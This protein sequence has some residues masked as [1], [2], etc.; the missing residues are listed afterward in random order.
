M[1]SSRP[2]ARSTSL[3]DSDA[4]M[5]GASGWDAIEWTK[6]EPFSR[7]V[8]LGNLECLLEAEQIVA[9][10]VCGKRVFLSSW[11]DWVAKNVI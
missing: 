8:S 2:R 11:L 6:I 1:A 3:R 7:S 4:P 5:E 10:N 9:E